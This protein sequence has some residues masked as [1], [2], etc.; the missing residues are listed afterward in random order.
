MARKGSNTVT[1]ME[2][3]SMERLAARGISKLAPLAPPWILMPG[4]AIGGCRKYTLINTQK[5]AS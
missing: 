2:D 4:A 3:T 5:A 1:L